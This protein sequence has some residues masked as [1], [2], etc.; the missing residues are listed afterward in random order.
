VLALK[1][2]LSSSFVKLQIQRSVM[3]WDESRLRLSRSLPRPTQ[4]LAKTV[5][6]AHAPPVA[7]ALARK[8]LFAPH[9]R[10]MVA[11]AA[12][13]P[14][15]S[16][17][18]EADGEWAE[19]PHDHA[20]QVR[21]VSPFSLFLDSC[22]SRLP[23]PHRKRLTLFGVLQQPRQVTSICRTDCVYEGAIGNPKYAQCCKIHWKT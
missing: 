6:A 3:R 8:T 17:E 22:L 13:E 9:A 10:G 4:A 23:L 1:T 16:E 19:A 15:D 11:A 21:S 2:H 20:S 7:P 18:P 14:V 5:K 12:Q